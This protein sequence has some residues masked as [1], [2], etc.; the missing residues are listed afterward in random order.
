MKKSQWDL[1]AALEP[2]ISSAR[3]SQYRR[4]GDTESIVLARYFWNICL[5]ESLYPA[6][7]TLEVTL[8]NR[9]YTVLAQADGLVSQCEVAVSPGT[10]A[11]K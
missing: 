3:I 4:P 11:A 9:I 2:A 6:L 7:A 10:V 1:F 5:S 8:R